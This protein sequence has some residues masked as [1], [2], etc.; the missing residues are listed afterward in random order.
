VTNGKPD[1]EGILRLSKEL[2][3]KPE[4]IVVFEDA[5]AG[6]K[7]AKNA[8]AKVIACRTTHTVEQLK[9]ANADCVVKLLT[10]VDFTMLS[11]GSFEI[12]VKNTL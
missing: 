4:E 6:I 2:G 8:G 5:P 1:P 3:F 9:E 10:D 12:E 11:D 7:A